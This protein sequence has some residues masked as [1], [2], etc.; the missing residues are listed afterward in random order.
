MAFLIAVIAF[1]A[2]TLIVISAFMFLRE[3]EQQTAITEKVKEFSGMAQAEIA[4]EGIELP[5]QPLAR[6]FARVIRYFG[7][8][9]RP[10]DKEEV[11][12]IQRRFLRAGVRRRNA[13][14]VFFGF[15]AVCAICLS[16]GFLV[17]ILLFR[18][19]V[20]LMG[21]M[22]LVILLS[23]VGFYLPNLWLSLKTSR[24]QDAFLQG[25]PDA[26]DLLA[27][28]AEAGMGLDAAIKR[29]GEEMRL[30]NKVLSDE[31]GMLNLEMRA[32]KER[33]EAMKSMAD[34]VNLEDVSSWV[35]LLI[36]T[37][38][39]GTSISQA[40]KIQSDSLRTKRSQRLEEIA[41]KVPV[42]LLFPT[43]FCIFPSLFV[44]ILGPAAIRILRVI[45]GH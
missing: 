29:V 1:I 42:K 2:V 13:L 40:L 35:S 43:I 37:D 3:R 45:S 20:P 44:V 41:A 26:L 18:P 9:L 24:R 34:R 39:L 6:L 11:S 33:K 22:V 21:A 25:F 4:Q 14:V 38:K 5:T 36:Q 19:K 15:K 23:L 7:N 16:M 8:L 10:Q 32:G 30:S 17:A 12:L 27:V 28:C 31:F